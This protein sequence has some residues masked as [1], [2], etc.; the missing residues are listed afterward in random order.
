MM[1]PRRRIVRPAV[2]PAPAPDQRRLQR[3]RA[4]LERERA[5]L[6]RWTARLKRAFNAFLKAQQRV[7]RLE[8]QLATAEDRH[9]PDH[10]GGRVADGRDDRADEG[11]R[12]R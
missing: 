1:T 10:R 7:A 2:P 12:R 9:G 6:A 11:V 3:L 5:A 8:R 4:N